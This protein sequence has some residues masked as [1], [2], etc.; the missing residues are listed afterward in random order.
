[1]DFDITPEQ[2]Q[3]QETARRIAAEFGLEY[4][5]KLDE[6]HAFPHEMWRELCAAGIAGALLPVESGGSGG[7]MLDLVLMLEALTEG[8]AGMPLAQLFMLNPVFG[9]RAICAFGTASMRR[10]LLPGLADGSVRMSFALTEPDCGNNALNMRTS[11][12]RHG[13]GWRLCGQKVWI[14]GFDVATHLLVVARTMPADQAPRRSDGISMFLIDAARPGIRASAIAKAGTH[15]LASFSLFLDDVE[16][17]PEECIGTLDRSWP[18]LVQLLNAERIVTAAGLVG[19]GRLAVSLASAYA[20]D[21]RVFGDKPI[22]AYQGVQFPLAHASAQLQS[23]GLTNRKAA[24]LMDQGRPFGSEANAAKLLAAEAAC[25]ACDRAMQVMGGMGY[26]REFHVE[27]LWRDAR[28]FAIAPVPQ[29]L[30]LS[31]IA[32]HDLDLPRSH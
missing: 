21:R 4:W 7:G 9:G 29:E 11:A 14:S 31:F 24:W 25:A 16:V 27:R 5:R 17:R 2:Q 1:M 30:I 18:E 22:G 19:T 26:A 32:M 8:G 3:M 20:R 6:A 10:D 15:P 28:V 12:V 13:D 23:A